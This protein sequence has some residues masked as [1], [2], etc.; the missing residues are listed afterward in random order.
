MAHDTV[1]PGDLFAAPDTH[2]WNPIGDI[3][4]L[5]P[6]LFLVLVG[7]IVLG[8]TNIQGRWY[9]WAWVAWLAVFIWAAITYPGRPLSESEWF[10]PGECETYADCVHD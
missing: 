7:L 10:V 6:S 9:G 8:F 1:Y 5:G 2:A 3:S 4:L